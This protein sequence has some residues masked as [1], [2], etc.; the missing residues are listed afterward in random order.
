MQSSISQKVCAAALQHYRKLTPSTQLSSSYYLTFAWQGNNFQF[1]FLYF[2]FILNQEIKPCCKQNTKLLYIRHN[3]GKLEY[4][5]KKLIPS[6]A[7]M[8]FLQLFTQYKTKSHSTMTVLSSHWQPLLQRW[9]SDRAFSL[10]AGGPRFN[11]GPLHTKY[12]CT[13]CLF[14]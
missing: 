1:W 8:I 7:I 3:H 4:Y 11:P 6:S 13:R 5:K 14:V 9:L 2:L 12:H 10:W